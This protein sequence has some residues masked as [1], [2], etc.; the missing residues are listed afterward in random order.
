MRRST[1]TFWIATLIL[2]I[3]VIPDAV[4]GQG[5]CWLNPEKGKV[6]CEDSGGGGG[7]TTPT[8][9]PAD[10][11]IYLYTTNRAPV[12]DCYY[13][14]SRPGGLDSSNSVNDSAILDIVLR[15]PRCPAVPVIDAEAAAWAIFRS[16]DLDPPEPVMQPST[17]GITGLPS[18]LST[19]TPPTITHS[20]VLPDGRTLTVQA[21]VSLLKVRWGD[22]TEQSFDPEVAAPYPTGQV[23]HL[24]FLKTCDPTYRSRHPSGG[25]C[26]PSLAS[27]PIQATFVWA[28]SYD[29][30]AGWTDLGTLDR[31]VTIDY[32]VDEARGVNVG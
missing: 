16:W 11:L 23:S 15:L 32:D 10:A 28:G 17:A 30:G 8:T 19:P 5:T 12:G 4:G 6:I 22:G 31:S 14:S 29:A 21:E 3:L 13:W 18:F 1:S 7:G 26:H 20:E 2:S 9:V 25:L 27:Y 24:Y